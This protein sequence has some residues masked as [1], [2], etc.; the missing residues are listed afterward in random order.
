MPGILAAIIFII[1]TGAIVFFVLGHLLTYTK[2][3]DWMGYFPSKQYWRFLQRKGARQT[4]VSLGNI[5]QPPDGERDAELED[6]IRCG[7]IEEARELI[8]LRFEEAKFAPVGGERKMRRA[9]HY[10]QYL[11]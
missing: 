8:Q 5:P 2:L 4:A 6:L 11:D 7:K 9:A 3:Y 10:A 1:V